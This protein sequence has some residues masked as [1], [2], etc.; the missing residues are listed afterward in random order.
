[1]RKV[2]ITLLIAAFVLLISYASL[3][4]DTPFAPEAAAA[5]P[6]QEGKPAVSADDYTIFFSPPEKLDALFTAFL[7]AL[8]LQTLEDLTTS[9]EGVSALTLGSKEIASL[10]EE[11]GDMPEFWQLRYALESSEEKKPLD[12][13]KRATELAPSD[14]VSLFLYGEEL[15]TSSNSD[16]FE[17]SVSRD[18]PLLPA[19]IIKEAA[20]KDGKNAYMYYMAAQ[21]YM[22]LGESETTLE[23]LDAGNACPQ[24][25]RVQLFP[26]SYMSRHVDDL[27]KMV[28]SERAGVADALIQL[29]DLEPLPDYIGLKDMVKEFCVV[30]ALNGDIQ[31]LNT[32]HRFAC[33]M[34][35]T[36]YTSYS[37]LIVAEAL[38]S[39][40]A[41][42][43]VANSEPLSPEEYAAYSAL[44]NQLGCIKG[45]LEGS[46][47]IAMSWP[48]STLGPFNDTEKQPSVEEEAELLKFYYRSCFMRL[49]VEHNQIPRM[50]REMFQR[51]EIFDYSNPAAFGAR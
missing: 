5:A 26:Y 21:L 22:R 42:Y 32:V 27:E 36:E 51:L 34:G 39:I 45:T 15:L 38:A 47:D 7:A 18:W 24:N 29:S 14:A 43:V 25:E 44:F 49:V 13:L 31:M 16:D 19:S 10:E 40:L 20:E 8:P 12:L 9:S 35:Q 33:R 48:L 2:S 6:A 17:K 30:A 28:G 1:M 4:Q 23:L 41:Q 37:D 11:F 3:A 46:M 50:T